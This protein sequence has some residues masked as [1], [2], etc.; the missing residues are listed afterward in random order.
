MGQ[1]S[2][3]FRDLLP[4]PIAPDRAGAGPEGSIRGDA[5]ADDGPLPSGRRGR[6]KGRTVTGLGDLDRARGADISPPTPH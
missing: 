4:G 2:S 6:V 3:G 1:P 5:A